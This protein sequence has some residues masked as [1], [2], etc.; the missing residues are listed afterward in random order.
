MSAA[1]AFCASRL[2]SVMACAYSSSVMSAVA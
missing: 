1:S 2:S